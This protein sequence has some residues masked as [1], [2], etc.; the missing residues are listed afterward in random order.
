[1]PRDDRGTP[2]RNLTLVSLH[3]HFKHEHHHSKKRAQVVRLGGNVVCSPFDPSR[4]AILFDINRESL[5]C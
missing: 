1:M 3:W 2:G 5:L 4:R